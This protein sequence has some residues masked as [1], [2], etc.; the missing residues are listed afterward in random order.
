MGG[1]GTTVCLAVVSGEIAYVTNVGDSRIYL[2]HGEELTPLTVDHTVTQM[3][4]DQGEI[5]QE[6]ARDHEG[7]HYLTKAV[8]IGRTVDPAYGRAALREGDILL[9][10]SAGLYNMVP[11][12]E[13]RRL[14][15]QAA[16]QDDGGCLIEEANRRGGR[17]N[18]T[19]VMI[20]YG[21]GE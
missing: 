21:K 3:L 8:G 20:G 7:R 15:R 16:A 17:D 4:L 14:A 13:M 5:T 10:C 18:I 1:M 6:E 12:P 11:A 2:L 19:A 9:L